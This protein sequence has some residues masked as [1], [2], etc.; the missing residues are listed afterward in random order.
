V[1]YPKIRACPRCGNKNMALY[2]Y[3]EKQPLNWHVECDE[4]YYLGPY[5]NKLQA[6][7]LHN[8]RCLASPASPQGEDE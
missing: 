4:C 6:I 7:R 3:G 1:S 5:G 8:E 2:G